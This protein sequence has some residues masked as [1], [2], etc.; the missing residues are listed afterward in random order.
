[1]QNE[2]AFIRRYSQGRH[3]C[4][5][6]SQRQGIYYA[7]SGLASPLTG[8]GLVEIVL[9]EDQDRLVA[10]VDNGEVA[11]LFLGTGSY[12]APFLTLN[13][14]KLAE[15]YRVVANNSDDTMRFLQLVKQPAH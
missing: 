7:E 1:V 2:L 10:S 12:S 9:Q 6:L 8:A 15:N 11:C 5:I 14:E 3:A 13:V 4:L